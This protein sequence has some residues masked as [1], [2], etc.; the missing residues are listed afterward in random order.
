MIIFQGIKASVAVIWL[1]M[2]FTKDLRDSET[3]DV[4]RRHMVDYLYSTRETVCLLLD[5]PV[6]DT[7]QCDI[8]YLIRE[9]EEVEY[10]N[11]TYSITAR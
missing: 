9:E 2:R 10:Q 4:S 3:C 11:E 6:H 5:D 1:I 7:P 8:L